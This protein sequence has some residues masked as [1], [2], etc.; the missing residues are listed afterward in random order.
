MALTDVKVRN[1]KAGEKQKK[2]FDGDGL[3]LLI[4]PPGKKTPNGSKCW[5]L[6]YRFGGKEKL[7][8]LGTYPEVSL[9]DARDRRSEARKLLANGIDPGE[10][11]KTKKALDADN[12][13]NTFEVVA[14]D[15]Y[16]KNK[17][18]WSGGHSTTVL[19]YL[20]KNAFPVIGKRPISTIT[21]PDVLKMLQDIESR[22]AISTAHRV[23]AICSQIFEYAISIGKTVNDPVAPLR[24]A[25]SKHEVQH[26]AAITDPKEAAALL[27]AIDNYQGSYSV[28]CALRFAPLVFVRPGEL[29]KAEWSEIDLDKAEWCIPAEKMKMKSPHIVPLSQQAVEI[30]KELFPLTGDGKY[31][32]PG[33]N[34]TQ[35]I[36]GNTLTAA[37]GYMGYEQDVM[38][39]H[40]F[41][42]M[43]RTILDEVLQV[44]ID[45]IEHQLAHKVIDPNG[46]AYNRTAHLEE[47][48]KM[49]QLWADYLDGLKAGA[50]VLPFKNPQNG[51]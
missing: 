3:F 4:M 19:S 25:L 50:T 6:K 18:G 37:L 31:V 40:G 8:A 38:S 26:L 7:L 48:R 20:E 23:R 49:M 11:R 28:K 16:D 1:E 39:A 13:A 45:F 10:E 21:S 15:W 32:F 12:A 51:N 2:L 30:L 27:R 35:P 5:R 47:R 42:A 43:A 17:Q 34:R 24:K 14:R 22:K 29:R 33:R 9:S 36:S 46:R 44:R 41:R